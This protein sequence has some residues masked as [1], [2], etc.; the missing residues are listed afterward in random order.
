MIFCLI[1]EDKK[2]VGL[3][4]YE[5]KTQLSASHLTDKSCK[6]LYARKISVLYEKLPRIH[7]FRK[8]FEH[9]FPKCSDSLS[10]VRRINQ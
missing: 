2:I 9:I 1:A 8:F 4:E 3:V 7:F 6:R 5:V 10:I